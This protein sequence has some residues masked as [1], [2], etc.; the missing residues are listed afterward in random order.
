MLRIA[1]CRVADYWISQYCDGRMISLNQV[2][3]EDED[4]NKVGLTDTLADEKATGLCRRK[5]L[6]NN[7][8]CGHACNSAK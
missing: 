4:A 3:Y 6:W 2:L 7:L 1:Y 5:V 8:I